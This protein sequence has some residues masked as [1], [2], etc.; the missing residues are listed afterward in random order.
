MRNGQL[1]NYTMKGGEGFT[2]VEVLLATAVGGMAVIVALALYGG[3]CDQGEAVGRSVSMAARGRYALGQIRDDLANVYWGSDVQIRQLEGNAGGE[4]KQPADRLSM[5]V[6]G[7]RGTEGEQEEVDVRQVEY[8]LSGRETASG[9]L[10]RRTRAVGKT[11]EVGADG[12]GV[13]IGKGI[14]S[15]RFDYFDGKQWQRQ[16]PGQSDRPELVRV[17]LEIV[18][19]DGGGGKLVVSQ[20]IGLSRLALRS[21]S[22]GVQPRDRSDD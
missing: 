4:E 11:G 17:T 13:V 22:R 16:W 20:E 15:L 12:G 9:T 2:L 3:V 7:G 19:Q 6:L 1:Y 21:E 8:R 14:R 18:D 10:E 5:Y